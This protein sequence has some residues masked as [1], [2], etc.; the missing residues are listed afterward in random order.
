MTAL[1]LSFKSVPSIPHFNGIEEFNRSG[2]GMFRIF[3]WATRRNDS[4][5]LG[6]VLAAAAIPLAAG[7]VVT[8]WNTIVSTA[9]VKNGGKSAGGS[10]IWFAYTSLAVYDAV[11]AITGQY[12]PF[13][14]RG[15]GPQTAS[16]EAAAAAAAHRVLTNYFPAQQSDLDA[17]F[18]AS[19][20]NIG[21]DQAAKDAGVSVAAMPSAALVLQPQCRMSDYAASGV[22]G[23]VITASSVPLFRHNQTGYA[24]TQSC[25]VCSSVNAG[26]TTS[27]G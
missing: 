11:N 17:R 23:V 14:Y 19:L 21:A 9:I 8:D 13:Y 26:L 12:R 25:P 20:S 1:K 7:N 24:S 22:A 10:A 5:I 2:E 3:R 16:V 27:G 4:K 15:T 18:A 6:A